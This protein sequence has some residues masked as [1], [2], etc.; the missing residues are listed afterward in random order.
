MRHLFL[1]VAIIA[2]VFSSCATKEK[3]NDE[4]THVHADGTVHEAHEHGT[5]NQEA[6]E[7]KADKEACSSSCQKECAKACTVEADSTKC[8]DSKTEEKH[9]E[10]HDHDHDHDHSHN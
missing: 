2:L 4:G 7:V 1:A 9:E 5:P 6:F 8:C 3:K 10:A